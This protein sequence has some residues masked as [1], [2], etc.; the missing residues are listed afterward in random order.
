MSFGQGLSGLNAASQDL[1]VIG[2]NIANSSTVGFKAS[3]AVFADVYAQSQAVGLGVQVSDVKQRFSVGNINVTGGQYD[4]AIDGEKG[5][6][7]M[8]D[9]NGI[10]QYTRNGQFGI[11]ENYD[12]VNAQGARLTGFGV[13]VDGRSP[14]TDL[15]PLKLPVGNMQPLATSTITTQANLNANAPVITATFDASDAST[16][17][18][19]LPITVYDSLGNRHEL[20]QYF[21]K[22]DPDPNFPGES[23][24][25]VH[26]QLANGTTAVA[27]ASQTLRF[28]D[29]GAMTAGQ[30]ATLAIPNPG[31]ATSP[32]ADMSINLS[33]AGSTS[34]GSDFSSSF[35][36]NG[37]T[38]GEF[39]SI[40]V[41]ND[42]GIQAHYTNGKSQVVGFVA[43]ANFANMQ[44]LKPVGGN[45][46]IETSASGQAV[47]GQP[48]TNGLAML[49]G[50]AVEASNV[51]MSQELVNMIIAQRTYQAN[52]QAIKTQ[53]QLMQTLITLR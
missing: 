41:A 7:R 18:H 32:S 38:T 15:Q 22:Q 3:S 24:W 27:P 25:A 13:A 8:L 37:Y 29:N 26:Y 34:Y 1:D 42:G 4:I 10:L 35:T 20:T 17:T 31:G 46:W 14:S 6:F 16:Y 11:S 12:I 23:Q 52:A 47:V 33:Y 53:D 50:Q 36:Q 21:V 43:L 19:M 51:D 9:V 48:G 44:G 2:N 5:F 28:N 49:K 39:A 45:A 30:T 40:S